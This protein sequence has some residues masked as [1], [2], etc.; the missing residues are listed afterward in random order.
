M[1]GGRDDEVGLIE[2][3]G[4]GLR[5]PGHKGWQTIAPAAPL[6]I[7]NEVAGMVVISERGARPIKAGGF[8]AQAPHAAAGPTCSVS[9]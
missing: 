7:E 9:G 3:R 6:Q 4:R 2:Q 8:A 5:H 1:H